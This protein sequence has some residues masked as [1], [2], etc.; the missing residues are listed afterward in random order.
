MLSS[1][2]FDRWCNHLGIRD[3]TRRIIEVE[4]SSEPSRRVKSGLGNWRGFYA[5]TKMKATRDFESGNELAQIKKKLE[6]NDAVLEYFSQP[7]PIGLEYLTKNNKP[8]KCQHTPDFFVIRE[9]G[10]GWVECK[11]EEKLLALTEQS[12]NR[13]VQ[14]EDGT[15]CC[16]PGE[17]Y[18]RERGLF[19][20]L[21]SSAEINPILIRNIDWLED[22]YT[23]PPPS[24]DTKTAKQIFSLIEAE[25]GITYAEILKS[26]EGI[27]PDH[28]NILIV[29][30]QVYVDLETVPLGRPDQVHLFTD[31]TMAAAYEQT[32]QVESIPV[33]EG[34]Q[35]VQIDVGTSISW[36]GQSWKVLNL[37]DGKV[38]LANEDAKIADL[39]NQEFDRYLQEGKIVAAQV[40]LEPCA[41]QEGREILLRARPDA[42]QKAQ[43]R[44]A[45]I[46]PWLG[47]DPPPYPPRSI[48]RWVTA[49]REA[50]RHYGNGYIGLLPKQAGKIANPEL[51]QQSWSLLKSF[52]SK[53][54]KLKKCDE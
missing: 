16:P 48:R 15:W 28:I 14:R 54:T 6:H 32:K 34:F 44:L 35:I 3:S 47:E 42:H 17:T 53:S 29:T 13:Y 49:Y 45:A 41:S 4:R 27:N 9:D 2:D 51:I 12:P 43:E 10:A 26:I 30:E 40:E 37:G 21:W 20:E 24:I 8:Y 19:Y 52:S 11:T 39:S 5:S 7:R 23:D 31:Q 50:E 25:L 46:K 38:S 22:Y 1:A 36:D 18:A 33:P